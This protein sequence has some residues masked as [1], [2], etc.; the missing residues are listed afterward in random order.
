MIGWL[1]S[2]ERDES[3]L[4]AFRQGLGETGFIE[5]RNVAIEYRWSENQDDRLPALAADLVRR[6]VQVIAAAAGASS[7]NAARG[8]SATIPIVFLSGPDPVRSGIVASLNRPGGNLTGVT[9]LSADLTAKR[10]SLLHSLLTQAASIALLLDWRPG[11]QILGSSDFQL[12][13]AE[14]AGSSL[15]FRIIGVRT[16][17]KDEFE[18]AFSTAIGEGSAALLVARSAFFVGRRYQLVALAAKY[19]LPAIYQMREY[20]AAG[21]LM[22]Y[23]PSLTDSFRQFGVYTGRV[24]KGEKPNDLPVLQPTRFE[25]VINLGTARA[26]GIE[27]PPTVLAITDEVID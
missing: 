14:A 18:A 26:L 8:A 12:K 17:N 24:L 27:V 21:G 16:D 5:G 1:F 25:F 4:S 19:R 2:G 7:V 15:G 9:V 23:G 11:A 22:S 13:E 10:L 3:F 20:A 6:R